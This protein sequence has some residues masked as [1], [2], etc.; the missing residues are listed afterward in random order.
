MTTLPPSLDLLARL[1]RALPLGARGKA[2]LRLEAQATRAF[3]A[4]A[5]G[6]GLALFA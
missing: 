1:F 3:V 2:R 5:R 4:A 6:A